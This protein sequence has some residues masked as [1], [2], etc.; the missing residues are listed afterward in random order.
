[1]KLPKLLPEKKLKATAR[2]MP[3][4]AMEYE[5]EEPAMKFSSAFMVVLLLHVTAFGGIWAFNNIKAHRIAP[6][7]NPTKAVEA[8]AEQQPAVAAASISQEVAPVAHV[9]TAPVVPPT[10]HAAASEKVPSTAKVE[11]SA[12]SSHD[13]PSTSESRVADSGTIYTAVKGDNPV[14][15]AHHF[16]VGYDDLLKLNNIENPKKL[17]IGQKLHIPAKQKN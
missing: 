14:T 15:I 17:Q 4:K 5:E 8:E 2:R 11:E 9:T 10:K 6:Y 12:T 7:T 3:Q 16:G 13:A 1:M